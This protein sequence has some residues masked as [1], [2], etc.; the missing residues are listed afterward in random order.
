MA[1]QGEGAGVFRLRIPAL[2]RANAAL[3]MTWKK[4][5]R[6]RITIPIM[7]SVTNNFKRLCS[8]SW[9]RLLIPC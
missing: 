6:D 3:K 5:D 7:E 1:G 8:E 9:A 2:A 4:Q